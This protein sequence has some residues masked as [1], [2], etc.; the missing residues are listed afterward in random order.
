MSY[1][2]SPK[3]GPQWKSYL[4]AMSAFGSEFLFGLS[5]SR[6]I[7]FGNRDVRSPRA[8]RDSSRP[9]SLV[10]SV[11]TTSERIDFVYSRPSLRCIQRWLS[12]AK[13]LRYAINMAA[14]N[15]EVAV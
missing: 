11:R 4:S 14:K 7:L 10:D 2:A 9:R 3:N 6:L 13:E 1:W 12:G 8:K 15:Q 5:L